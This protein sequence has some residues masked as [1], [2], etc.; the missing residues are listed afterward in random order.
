MRATIRWRLTALYAGLLIVSTAALL[1]LSHWLLDRHVHRTLPDPLADDVSSQLAGQ[2]AIA[3]AGTALLALA[4]GWIVAGRVLAPV[5]RMTATARR[6]SD[7]HLGERIA[8]DGPEDELRELAR[9]LDAMLDRLESHVEAQRRFA[10]NASHELRSPLAIIRA[11]TEVTLA[12]R[13][14]DSARYREMAETVLEAAERTEALLDSLLLLARSQRGLVRRDRADLATVAAAATEGAA[15]E[16]RE[17]GV[18]LHVDLRG[19]PV[20]GDG[21]L[22]ERLAANVVVNAIRHNVPGGRA[23]VVTRRDG[24][25][26]VLEVTNTGPQLDPGTVER[27]TEP[28]ERGGR[29]A[30]GRGAGLGLSIA[31]AVAEAHEG[32]LELLARPGG[33]LTVRASLPAA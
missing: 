24:E 19:A 32:R 7:E 4:L 13:D 29:T 27:L 25:R 20:C 5:A 30:D 26:A 21:A 16:A 17:R 22:L 28:F 2:Y 11:E 31:R 3:L 8:L 12:D 33:G 1:W 6:I 15:G 9:T 14:A 18:E 10:A 23:D